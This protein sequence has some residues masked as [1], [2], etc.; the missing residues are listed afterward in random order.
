MTDPNPAAIHANETKK[1]DASIASGAQILS[2]DYPLHE[3]AAS[4]YQVEV[5]HTT[6]RC[7][8]V[9]KPKACTAAKTSRVWRWNSGVS[10]VP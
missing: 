7:N 5:D 8:P 3:P 6:A 2:T 10:Q 4:G 9:L 1:R